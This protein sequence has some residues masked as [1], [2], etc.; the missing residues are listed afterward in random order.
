[1]TNMIFRAIERSHFMLL[2]SQAVK[3]A[4]VARAHGHHVGVT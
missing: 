3:Y 1:M 4:H 2:V